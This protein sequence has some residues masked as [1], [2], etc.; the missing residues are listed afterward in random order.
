M[1][2]QGKKRQAGEG[3]GSV[4]I[5][6]VY[7]SAIINWM[8]LWSTIA[9]GAYQ[10]NRHN[11]WMGG[12]R[13]SECYEQAFRFHSSFLRLNIEYK[14]ERCSDRSYDSFLH[15]FFLELMESPSSAS[16]TNSLTEKVS[17]SFLSDSVN[18]VPQN[19]S[20]SWICPRGTKSGKLLCK[21][22]EEISSTGKENHTTYFFEVL[23]HYIFKWK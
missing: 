16:L 4:T 17:Y 18:L 14:K 22:S 5:Q 1:V 20:E 6:S 23:K 8:W 7:L 12:Q 21:Y 19:K 2:Q 10:I 15:T 13:T 9:T 3:V 11:G